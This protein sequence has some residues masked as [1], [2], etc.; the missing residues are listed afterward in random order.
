[1]INNQI[2]KKV[3]LVSDNNLDK[4]DESDLLMCDSKNW[5]WYFSEIKNENNI[6]YEKIENV[7]LIEF[8]N[9]KEMFSFWDLL[10]DN[11]KINW[12]VE[13]KNPCVLK[14]V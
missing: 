4:I 12:S 10:S 9:K 13:H 8:E 3:Y 2:Y 1:M 6:D 11:E 7:E 14:Y 5:N